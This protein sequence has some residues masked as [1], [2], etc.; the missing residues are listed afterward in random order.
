[1]TLA[2]S[3]LVPFSILWSWRTLYAS[4]DVPTRALSLLR[5]RSTSKLN[6][7]NFSIMKSSK[8]WADKLVFENNITCL[9]KPGFVMNLL[10]CLACEMKPPPKYHLFRVP[11]LTSATTWS[12][13]RQT[14]WERERSRYCIVDRTVPGCPKLCTQPISRWILKKKIHLFNLREAEVL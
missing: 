9:P 5:E 1:M 3:N 12:W 11:V 13:E 6:K 10:T 2:V 7:M 14:T 8:F 4:S